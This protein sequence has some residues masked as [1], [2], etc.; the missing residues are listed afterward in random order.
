VD[1]FVY[2]VGLN[3]IQLTYLSYL[4]YLNCLNYWV[5]NHIYQKNDN[6]Y[7]KDG[8][9]YKRYKKIPTFV[10]FNSSMFLYL[11]QIKEYK[12]IYIIKQLKD[13]LKV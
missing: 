10:I 12:I 5:I 8:E 9:K 2:S 13:I 7:I 1:I 6:R 4:N 3:Y 11:I